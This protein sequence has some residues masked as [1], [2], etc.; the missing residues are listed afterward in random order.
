MRKN[1]QRGT[2]EPIQ[3]RSWRT[4]QESD[5]LEELDLLSTSRILNVCEMDG[6]NGLPTEC[7]FISSALLLLDHYM[8]S[9][10]MIDSV[11]DSP[12]L[13]RLTVGCLACKR[14]RNLSLRFGNY[15]AIPLLLKSTEHV[16]GAD[17]FITWQ[18]T[19]RPKGTKSNTVFGKWQDDTMSTMKLV[20][21]LLGSGK[22]SAETSTTRTSKPTNGQSTMFSKISTRKKTESGSDEEGKF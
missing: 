15:A 4:P 19:L 11:M 17:T 18:L 7:H 16:T 12:V 13:A 3:A 8:A 22:D 20:S 2:V 1:T 6:N 5:P 14:Q 9:L 21:Q 10:A